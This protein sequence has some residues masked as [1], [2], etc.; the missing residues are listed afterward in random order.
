[1]HEDIEFLKERISQ[2]EKT[3]AELQE[4]NSLK[5]KIPTRE[6]NLTNLR[7]NNI[8]PEVISAFLSLFNI[9]AG[10][11]WRDNGAYNASDIL[12]ILEGSCSL[13][14]TYKDVIVKTFNNLVSEVSKIENLKSNTYKTTEDSRARADIKSAQKTINIF[15]REQMKNVTDP[16]VRIA[17]GKYLS[18]I[19]DTMNNL[20]L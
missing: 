7:K 6:D 2:L 13:S 10:D 5:Q 12:H 9:E 11:F 3:V 8:D 15:L 1:M 16:E 17:I 18:Y 19:D 20:G 4:Q 14:E